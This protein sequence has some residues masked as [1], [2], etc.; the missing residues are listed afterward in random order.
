MA[1]KLGIDR[2]PK[3]SSALAVFGTFVVALAWACSDSGGALGFAGPS[4]GGSGAQPVAT[5]AGTF[6]ASGSGTFAND[7]DASAS[8]DCLAGLYT[9]TFMGNYTS[10]LTVIGFPVPVNGKLSLTLTESRS[11]GELPTYTIENGTIDGLV[12]SLYPFHCSMVGTLDCPNR[13][14]VN[15]GVDCEYCIGTVTGDLADGGTC[16]R[17]G[18]FAGPLGATYSSAHVFDGTW[19]GIDGQS[20][21]DA[22]SVQTSGVNDAGVYLGPGNYGGSGTWKG[23]YADAGP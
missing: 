1:W 4:D 15:G 14:L 5:D 21:P 8:G 9:G 19:N 18:Y 12:Y 17:G 2:A 22:S 10:S 7:S 20:A 13:V 16:S 23:T 6:D 3:G 11:Q